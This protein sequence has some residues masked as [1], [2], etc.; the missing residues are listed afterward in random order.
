M[1]LNNTCEGENAKRAKGKGKGSSRGGGGARRKGG[2]DGRSG[3]EDGRSEEKLSP[4]L[5][6]SKE[7]TTE[8]GLQV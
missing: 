3:G 6:R 1:A 4:A 2:E 8:V 5:S 7:P